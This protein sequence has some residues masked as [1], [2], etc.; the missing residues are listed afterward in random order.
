[1]RVPDS[2]KAGLAILASVIC[3]LFASDLILR[4][5]GYLPQVDH[6]WLLGPKEDSRT[7]DDKLILV[8]PQFLTE[9]FYT[10][11]PTRKIVVTLGDSYVEGYPVDEND[12][13]PSVLGR[14]LGE[15]D[16][17]VNILN[18]GTG[19]SGPG[20][21]LRLMKEY[22]LPRLTPDIV[23]WSFY[24]NDV[25]DNVQQPVY[26]IENGSLVQLDASKHWLHIRQKL[27]GNIPLPSTIKESSPVLRL[28]FR[29][30][31]I[32]GK[33]GLH[34]EEPSGQVRS[35]EKIRLQIEEMER[36]ARLHGFKVLYVLIAPQAVYLREQDPMFFDQKLLITEYMQLR[37]IIAGQARH[38]DVWFGG[39]ESRFCGS[40]F[41]APAS[42]DLFSDDGRDHNPL[43]DRHFNETGYYLLA[44][45]V[46]TCL[47]NDTF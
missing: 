29:A 32:C 6:E 42:R 22:L 14:L 17:P 18:M 4:S 38:V 35:V 43:G 19:D 24:A 25:M 31:E 1:V 37:P 10:V 30:L 15:R 45:I 41:S 21:Q 27:Y 9:Q 33:R 7:P 46:A 8:R 36:L 2:L 20:Q 40:P 39:A 16:Q 47:L 28:F 23:V 13:Y 3:T 44:D 5:V 12:N 34:T 11:D 26:N